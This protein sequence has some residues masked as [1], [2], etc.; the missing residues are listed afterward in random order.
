MRTFAW[1]LVA[2][3]GQTALLLV[4]RHVIRMW[5]VGAAGAAV[6]M[7]AA[8]LI[9][10]CLVLPRGGW[11]R[12]A[13]G[14]QFWPL[15][16]MGFEAIMVNVCWFGALKYT[17]A[18]NAA[19][20]QRLDLLFVLLLAAALG[21][22]PLHRAQ[23]L[24]LPVLL[25][26]A[27]LVMR[28]N[29]FAF[30]GAGGGKLLG[31]CLVVVGAFFLAANA[32]VIR[33]IMRHM[34][35][36]AIGFYNMLLSVPGFLVVIAVEGKLGPEPGYSVGSALA[37]LGLLG[38]VSATALVLYYLAMRRMYVWRLRALMLLVPLL[39]IVLERVLWGVTLAPLQYAGAALLIGGTGLL[40]VD[41]IRH[42]ASRPAGAVQREK[43]DPEVALSI[44]EEQ[45]S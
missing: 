16:L 5:P 42:R 37:W 9:A 14:T 29:E 23:L 20:L 32:F 21:L 4:L 28:V 43:P 27:A 31:D 13:I 41:E 6:R 40:I 33:G 2:A 11:R 12:L 26:G 17:T 10:C 7:I 38:V 44:A 18:T 36:D 15:M 19:V 34:E 35:E 24:I 39:T 3:L 1:A 22:E 25:G 8:V 45:T 30:G